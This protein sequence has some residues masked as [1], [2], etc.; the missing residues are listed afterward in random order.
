MTPRCEHLLFL[1]KQFFTSFF[2][3]VWMVNEIKQPICIKSCV[4]LGKFT[5]ETHE[6][7]REAFAEYSML[8]KCGKNNG[9]TIYISEE[10]IRKEMAA[11]IKLSQRLFSDLGQE[12]SDSPRILVCPIFDR[13]Y[14]Y[15]QHQIMGWLQM[16]N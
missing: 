3:F 2:P 16:I 5:T 1:N 11:K 13:T 7:L 15:M 12:L 10:T 9:I 6:M 4:K 8:L 14:S